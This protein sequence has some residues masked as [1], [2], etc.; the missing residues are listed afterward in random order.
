MQ[1]L[2][3]NFEYYNTPEFDAIFN[4]IIP[5]IKHINLLGGEPLFNSKYYEILQKVI[6]SGRAH[7]VSIQFNTNLLA[8][9]DKSFDLWK[10]FKYVNANIS[11]DGVDI[12]NEYVRY[13]GK[14]SK[15]IR[16]LEKIT[17]W[18]TQLGGPDRLFLQI[19]ATMSSLTWLN[20]GELFKWCQ[21][22]PHALK[23]PFLIQVNQPSYMDCIHMPDPIKQLGYERICESLAGLE[24]WESKNI[25]SLVDHVI[26]TTSDP[27]KWETMITETNKL[28]RVRSSNI[29]DIIPE[30]KD[31][32]KHD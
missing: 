24:P 29:I 27:A 31:F 10:E 25:F 32:W 17:D 15:F 3:V 28:D 19:H 22:L 7:E 30:Y 16:N 14:W 9:Q 18:Q 13:P 23:T 11:C 4:E 8:L 26:N 6:D 12:V 2:S 21:T 5:T 20:L 1:T